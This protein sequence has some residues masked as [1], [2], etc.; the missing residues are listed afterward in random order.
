MSPDGAIVEAHT[1]GEVLRG[2]TYDGLSIEEVR[3]PPKLAVR[4]HAHAQAQIYFLLEGAYVES[5]RTGSHTLRPGQTWFRPPGELHQN[6]VVG[7]DAALTLILSVEPSRYSCLEKLACGPG[8]L[9]SLLVDEVRSEMLREIGAA[10]AAAGTALEG[11]ALLLLSHT[12]RALAGNECR[13]PE[14]LSDAVHFIDV[15]W[16]A[17][18][19]LT[20]VAAH[21]GV[22]PATL[23]SA[24]RR[25]LKT[26]VGDYLRRRRLAWAREALI[27]SRRPI[28]AIAAEAG[29]YDQAHFGRCF[30]AAFGVTPACA[31]AL[32]S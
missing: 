12:Q 13:R 10:D 20:S 30:K 3:M 19:S 24:F 29:F 21:V 31:R 15:G 5:C 11:W 18:L 16:R 25:F 17:P 26:S 7:D 9:R 22:H 2:R 32:S 28:K 4:P 8:Q 14:W 6:A 23:A 1:F 27:Y